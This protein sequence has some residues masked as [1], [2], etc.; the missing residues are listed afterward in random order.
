MRDGDNSSNT[1]VTHENEVYVDAGE[2]V[3][4]TGNMTSDHQQDSLAS[5]LFGQLAADY[6]HK[7]TT[8]YKQWISTYRK[9]LGQ[10]GWVLVKGSE[11]N[12]KVDDYF[13]V[14]EILLQLIDGEFNQ[15]AEE[16][17]V[18]DLQFTLNGFDVHKEAAKVFYNKTYSLGGINVAI[19]VFNEGDDG[20]VTMFSTRAFLS[21][22]EASNPYL[23]HLFEPSCVGD[24]VH[25]EFERYRLNEGTYS[26]VRDIIV[27]KLGSR[28]KEYVIKISPLDT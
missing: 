23:F 21:V 2:L 27:Q 10:I 9:V 25:V 26:N 15:T 3:I 1:T 19:N 22:C 14:S 5:T 12:I 16:E 6:K 17:V 4:L 20:S 8:D 13:V 18:Q 7:R 28:M 11:Q 24:R